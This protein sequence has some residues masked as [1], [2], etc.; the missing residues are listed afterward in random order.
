[1]GIA[2]RIAV[3]TAESRLRLPRLLIE[4]MLHDLLDARAI[5]WQLLIRNLRSRFRSSYLGPIWSL[6]PALAMSVVCV[7]ASRAHAIVFSATDAPYPVFVVVG[8][9]L[10]QVFLESLNA[11]IQGVT[12]DS[13]VLTK[14]NFPAEAIILAKLAEVVFNSVLKLILIVAV[15]AYFKLPCTL[16]MCL[17]PIAACSLVLLGTFIGLLITP[18]CILFDDVVKLLTISTTYWFLITPVVYSAPREGLFAA[19]V[20]ANPVT[21]LLVTA[22]EL[23]TGSTLS[24]APAFI[25]V[26]LISVLGLTVSWVLFKLALPFV[27]ERK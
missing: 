26:T 10:W 4:Q 9:I 2:V 19:V 25:L 18:F 20:L 21:S 14:V 16:S 12:M 23:A 6:L 11:P 13:A 22:R 8:M 24:C 7:A 15:F 17:A 27:I 5:A 1:M 3:Y